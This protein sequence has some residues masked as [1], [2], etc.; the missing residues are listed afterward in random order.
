MEIRF[1]IFGCITKR[2]RLKSSFLEIC[3]HD[4]Q[5]ILFFSTTVIL[6]QNILLSLQA[7]AV[8]FNKSFKAMKHLAK[9]KSAVSSAE[10]RL[11]SF[12]SNTWRHIEME[13]MNKLFTVNCSVKEPL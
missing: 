3:V 12:S 5:R 10:W 4:L 11:N 2:K 6:I 9:V 1:S 7:D 13:S 8:I